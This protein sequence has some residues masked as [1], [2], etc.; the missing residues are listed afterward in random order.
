MTLTMFTNQLRVV[1]ILL[2]AEN[3]IGLEK[4]ISIHPKLL[5]AYLR[6]ILYT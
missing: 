4:H 3:A 6:C 1:R 2:I 5:E